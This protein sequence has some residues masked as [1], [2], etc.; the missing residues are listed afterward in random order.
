LTARLHH[1]A[2]D[3]AALFVSFDQPE[4]LAANDNEKEKVSVQ[5]FAECSHLQ[6]GDQ[7]GCGASCIVDV[8]SICSVSTSSISFVH[9]AAVV[10]QSSNI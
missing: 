8:C 9:A 10:A 4:L 2:S 3:A 7:S 1:L 5:D 6:A